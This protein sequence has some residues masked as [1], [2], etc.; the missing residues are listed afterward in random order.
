MKIHHYFN[1]IVNTLHVRRGVILP[2]S[3]P[4][5]RTVIFS[6]EIEDKKIMMNVF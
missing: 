2:I 3:R 5:R 4:L 1:E 6:L